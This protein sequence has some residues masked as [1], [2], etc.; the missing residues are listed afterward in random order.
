MH[1]RVNIV[2]YVK[3][4]SGRWN[5]EPIPR[6]SRTRKY[7]WSKAKSDHFY[8][9]WREN[10]RRRYQKA[11]RAPSEVLEAQ[12]RKEFELAGRAVL[13]NGKTIPKVREIG[14]PVEVAVADF[15]DFIAKKRRPNTHKRY[16]A[17]MEHFL[18]FFKPYRLV[19]SIE[20]AD[21]DAFRDER[22][23]HLNP[24]DKQITPKNV[25][26]EVAT[27]RAFYY[28]LQKFRGPSISNPAA[29]LKPLAVTKMIVDSYDEDELKNFFQACNIEERAIF[30]MFYYTG[31][32][33][34]ELAH[35]H[36]ADLDLKKG[37]V[38][39]RQKTEAGFVPKDWEERE[40]P[41]HPEL[42]TLLEELPRRNDLVFPSLK[43]NL[44]THLLRLL[45][46]IVKRAKLTGRWYLHKF[47]K[48]FA[49]R[50]LEKGADIRT[51]QALLGHKNITTTARYLSTSTERMRE[52]VSKL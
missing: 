38:A 5:W 52:A 22:L 26:Y 28:Y 39:V 6:N 14:L 1:R 19:T 23:T 27:I 15:L 40:L 30:K 34:Q 3:A 43:G 8:L 44:N 29:R 48:T 16:R 35:L 50:A 24:W 47:R 45:K 36:W 21:I 10:K 31:L 12:R 18:N 33:D 25:N 51:V 46:R 9:V 37:I 32:R 49:T 41:L 42:L 7:V 20:P 17:V 11:G 2:Q 4:A 13:E